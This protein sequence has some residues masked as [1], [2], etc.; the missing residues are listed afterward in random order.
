MS[1]PF[2][3]TLKHLFEARPIDG[4]RYVG[5]SVT[6]PVAVIDADLSTVSAE[7][8]KVI[9]VG[10]DNPWLAHLECQ[11]NYERRLGNRML[12]YNVLLG[13]RHDLPVDSTV[14]LL[15]PQ[16]DG[17]AMTGRLRFDVHGV[18]YLDFR[19]R[20]VRAWEQSVEVVLAG[21]LGTLPLAP[22]CDVPP[23][24]LPEVIGLMETRL[25]QEV[26]PAE[27]AIL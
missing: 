6:D 19:Y 25:R 21:G 11:A 20:V 7:A 24:R 4:L 12:R 22:L 26:V 18:E 23:E 14:I 9:R 3:P 27:A 8:D 13:D 10:G 5:L 1:K 16:A 2:D 15:R 17:P